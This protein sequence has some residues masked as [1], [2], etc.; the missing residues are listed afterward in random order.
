MT[1]P[2]LLVHTILCAAGTAAG[3]ACLLDLS[4]TGF[5][6]LAAAVLVRPRIAR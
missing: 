6:Y 1:M 5:V 4:P 3:V 2:R